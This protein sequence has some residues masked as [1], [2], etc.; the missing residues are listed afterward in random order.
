MLE[1]D[2]LLFRKTRERGENPPHVLPGDIVTEALHDHD[3][4]TRHL[5][6]QGFAEG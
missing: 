1:D 5:R 3:K 4:M 6:S 2:A